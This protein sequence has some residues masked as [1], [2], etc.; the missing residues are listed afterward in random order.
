MAVTRQSSHFGNSISWHGLEG[1]DTPH[2]WP[3]YRSHEL[4]ILEGDEKVVVF[5]HFCSQC[6]LVHPLLLM[7]LIKITM[8]N[9]DY[10]YIYKASF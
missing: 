5:V 9:D 7:K 4:V 1:F 3:M 10:I 6:N 2:F 8:I